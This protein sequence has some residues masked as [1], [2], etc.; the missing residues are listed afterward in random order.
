MQ[1]IVTQVDATAW[2][3]CQAQCERFA[4]RVLWYIKDFHTKEEM[5]AE[6]VAQCWRAFRTI[7]LRGED[8][9]ALWPRVMA[10]QIRTVKIG[11][12]LAGRDGAREP[13]SWVCQLQHGV[14]LC[15]LPRGDMTDDGDNPADVVVAA[16]DFHAWYGKLRSRERDLLQLS[17]Q[18]LSL[19][20]IARRLGIG[21]M[22]VMHRRADL[23]ARWRRTHPNW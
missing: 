18:G 12:R 22:A 16:M 23:L 17:A 1:R 5:T 4:A 13:Y 7:T 14:T 20:Q 11:C 2:P 3:T 21:K 8:A 6:F 19:R 15:G 10:T 9:K